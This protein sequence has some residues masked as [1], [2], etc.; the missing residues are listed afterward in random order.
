MELIFLLCAAI[1][2]VWWVCRGDGNGKQTAFYRHVDGKVFRY[3]GL[4]QNE[5]E[6]AYVI[7]SHSGHKQIVNADFFHSCFGIT[8]TEFMQV[9]AYEAQKPART[10][11]QQQLVRPAANTQPVAYPAQQSY[12]TQP[13]RPAAYPYQERPAQQQQPTYPYQPAAYPY[14]PEPE[15]YQR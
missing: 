11:R 9:S 13:E 4:V 3:I 7:E 1:G 5:Y 10:V 12:P 2:G 6:T 15:S 14:R 8:E